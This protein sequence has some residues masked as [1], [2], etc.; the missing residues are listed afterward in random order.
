MPGT[1]YWPGRLA[2]RS[3]SDA[4]LPIGESMIFAELTDAVLSTSLARPGTLAGYR[5]LSKHATP[6]LGQLE[7]ERIERSDVQAALAHARSAGL[8]P[9]SQHNLASFIRMVLRQGGS[10]AGDG[11]RVSVPDPNVQALTACQAT[12]LRGVLDGRSI[13]DAALL[14]LLD[15]GLRLGECL[16]L[17]A[18]S[19][20]T[21]RR[22]LQVVCSVTGPTKSGH[23]REVDVPDTLAPMLDAVVGG[24]DGR[25]FPVGERRVQRRMRSA[26]REAGLHPVRVHDLRHTRLTHLLLNGAPSLYVCQQAG[27]S[28]PVYTLKVYGHLAV[29]SSEQRREWCNA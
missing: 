3:S 27:H 1:S 8:G 22:V 28:S 5:R 2:G 26:C 15:T 19:W 7:V 11:V 24:S 10:T 4:E 14:T 29:A 23:H 20:D 9:K 12:Q 16:G 17:T 18:T 21:Q 25:L 6:T 13:V